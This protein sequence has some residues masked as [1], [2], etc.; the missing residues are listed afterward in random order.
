M[1]ARARRRRDH[2]DGAGPFLQH[3]WDLVDQIDEGLLL[4]ALRKVEARGAIET[5]HR[6]RQRAERVFRYAAGAGVK[7]S[8]PAV[9][10]RDALK[11]APPRKRRPALT[12]VMQIRRLIRDVDR[13]AASPVTR[14][15][16]RF[17]VLTAQRPGMVRAAMWPEIEGVDWRSRMSPHRVRC[18]AFPPLR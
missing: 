6:P 15:S 7:N 16:S 10:V 5:A 14:L 9:N 2:V 4:H 13:A 1:E 8:K 17:L 11:P 3:R 12:D 18:G